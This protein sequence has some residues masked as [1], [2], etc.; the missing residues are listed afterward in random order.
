MQELPG[1]L[2]LL[3]DLL[4]HEVR[5]AAL[6]DGVHRLGDEL[7]WPLDEA[8][9]GHRANLDAIG[10]QGDDLAVH[11]SHHG[12]RERQQRGQVRRDAG[13]PV[14]DPDDEPGPLLEGVE[15]IV[16]GPSDHEGVV[17]LEV[18]KGEPDG[19]DQLVA[20]AD[21]AFHRMDAGLAV[22]VGSDG[23]SLGQELDP[24]L[25]V[26]HD[27]AVVRPDH[28]AVGVEMGLGIGL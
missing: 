6:H 16:V 22:V 18:R 7:S 5:V 8:A 2:R 15:P 10:P 24:E 27:V 19:L 23:H 9:V 4:R 28:V 20:L 12:P 1:D 17:A 26:V 21:V 3:V 25:D 13:E 14:T 11:G